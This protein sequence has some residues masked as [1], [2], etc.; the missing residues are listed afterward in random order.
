MPE[1]GASNENW[2]YL[3]WSIIL[4]LSPLQ[5]TPPWNKEQSLKIL[6]RSESNMDINSILEVKDVI[7]GINYLR[8]I[9]YISV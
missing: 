1:V 9:G 4:A 8:E 3:P 2:I 5:D 7:K 6:S